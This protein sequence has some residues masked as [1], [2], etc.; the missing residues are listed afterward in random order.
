MELRHLRYFVA[1]ASSPT[2]TA[3]AERVHVTQ[4]TLSHQ[5]RQLEDELG[6]ELFRRIGKRRVVLSGAGQLFLNYATRALSEVDSGR[7]LLRQS[8]EESSGT[9]RIGAGSTFNLC[10][11]PECMARFMKKLPSV[12]IV[13]EDLDADRIRKGIRSGDIDVGVSWRP[14]DLEGLRFEPLHAE[15]LVL[16]VGPDHPFYGRKRMRMADLHQQPMVL[17]THQYTTRTLIESCFEACGAQL[18]VAAEINS[19]TPMLKLVAATRLGTI[20]SRYV[21]VDCP[22]PSIVL[23][24]SPTPTRHPGILWREDQ[25]A[26]FVLSFISII[27]EVAFDP[28]MS[29]RPRSPPR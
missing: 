2:F 28:S 24:E 18:V 23:L 22:T 10:F 26:P 9:L 11:I 6:V 16:V 17:P 5:I 25:E 19:L 29:L 12:L 15:E 8:Q 7:A 1:V 20:V 3:A 13:V 4:S 21:T 27:R 14:D